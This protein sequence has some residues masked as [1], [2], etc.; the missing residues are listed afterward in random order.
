MDDFPVKFRDEKK[1]CYIYYY[2]FEMFGQLKFPNGKS[3]K[4][5]GSIKVEMSYQKSVS[6]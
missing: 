5:Q 4:H 2:I 1:V 6:S 3:S